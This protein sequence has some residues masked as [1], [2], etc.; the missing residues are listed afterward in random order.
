MPY[1]ECRTAIAIIGA[2]ALV[3]LSG[4]GASNKSTGTMVTASFAGTVMPTAV[5]YQIGTTGKFQTLALSGSRASF[6]LPAGTSAYG[7]AYVCP[8]YMARNSDANESTLQATT[9]D[10]T[11]LSLACPSLSGS[12]N[13]TYDASAIPGV[14]SILFYAGASSLIQA[15]H[16]VGNVG[17]SGVPPGKADVALV[18]EGAN[19]ALAVQI[20]R[21]VN[22]TDSGTPTTV[23]FP[24]MTPADEVGSASAGITNVPTGTTAN[25]FATYNTTHGLSI[26]VPGPTNVAPPSTYWTVPSSQSQ[27]GDFYLI[28]AFANLPTQLITA[29]VSSSTA[30]AATVALPSPSSSLAAPTAAAFPTFIANTSGFTVSG[31]VVYSSWTQF[32]VDTVLYNAYTY[33]T[34][35][36]L[37]TNS[38]FTVPNLSALPGFAPAPTSGSHEFWTLYS[39]AGTPL[40]WNPVQ[41]S[42][43]EFL[44]SPISVQ[45]IVTGGAFNVP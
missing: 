23:V 31:T 10:T 20:M 13:A 41:Q 29:E 16:I 25:L 35:T 38:T 33:V 30:G 26:N 22:V 12:V 11:S 2:L 8:M 15:S 7:F 21:G 45:S 19:G 28:Q 1:N 17:L 32:T 27:S 9:A 14:T 24:P 36:W 4:C 34:K 5:A 40:Q 42:G 3:T 39:T 44:T 18:A 37:G 43:I 6:T